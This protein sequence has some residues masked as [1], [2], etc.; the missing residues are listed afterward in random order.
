MDADPMVTWFR[1]RL[2]EDEKSARAVVNGEMPGDPE[3]ARW[4]LDDIRAKRHL[5][6]EH[7]PDPIGK[8]GSPE[9]PRCTTCLSDR[10]GYE[11]LWLADEWPCRTV[12]IVVSGYRHRDG[13]QE[14]WAP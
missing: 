8:F 12:R 10:E 4:Q 14:G 1:A 6:D 5:L 7:R 3:L 11:E 13:W 9:R 2:A